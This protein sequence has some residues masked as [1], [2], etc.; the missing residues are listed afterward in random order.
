M[1]GH[2]AY[3]HAPS[4]AREGSIDQVG[5]PPGGN[6]ERGQTP[7]PKFEDGLQ[8]QHRQRHLQY[9]Y[10]PQQYQN[11]L[12]QQQN[13]SFP[14]PTNTPSPDPPGKLSP[15]RTVE[16]LA[17]KLSRHNL[18][19]L[20]RASH[21]QLP[22]Q[23]AALPLPSP[24]ILLDPQQLAA[25]EVNNQPQR[26]FPAAPPWLPVFAQDVGEAIEIDE[27]YLEESEDV[28]LEVTL[29][30]R[31]APSQPRGPPIH[32]RALDRLEDM[33]ESGTQCNVRA[34]PRPRT[35][36][37]RP[38]PWSM[39][40]PSPAFLEPDPDCTLPNYDPEMDD[41]Y[42]EETTRLAREGIARAMGGLSR[43]ARGPGGI[44][45]FS[46]GGIAL[47]Y[48]TSA[49]AALRCK[50]AVRSRPRMRKRNKTRHEDAVSSAVT[51]AAAAAPIMSAP[52]LSPVLPP[53]YPPP[54]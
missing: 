9:G 45:K 12:Q 46:V 20:N 8:H 53:L 40:I 35:R 38:V 7:V 36:P 42:D 5:L 11:Q 10:Q 14:L 19:Q 28:K 22:M 47:E 1:Y 43:H 50:N 34:E 27:G 26:H 17:H 25:P 18:E 13:A 15:G 51:A 30:Q 3:P 29:P 32:I 52:A 54:E 37:S 41:A 21:G 44:R 24:P 49:D 48:S 31:Q 4:A 33:I 16:R 2:F 39:P 23:E 6:A